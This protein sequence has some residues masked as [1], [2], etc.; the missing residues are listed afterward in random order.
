VR[1]EK[2]KKETAAK[3]N[4]SLALTTL[5]RETIIKTTPKHYLS[6]ISF[7]LSLSSLLVI[8]QLLDTAKNFAMFLLSLICYTDSKLY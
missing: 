6:F 4:G 3:Y 5:E 7:T 1:E 2:K 8:S